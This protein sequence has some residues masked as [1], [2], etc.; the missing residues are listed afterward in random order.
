LNKETEVTNRTR[1]HL[2]DKFPGII[3]WRNSIGYDARAKVYYG[4]GGRGGSD[5]IGMYRGRFIA[6]EAKAPGSHTDPAH[7][8]DQKNFIRVIRESG[9]IA[10]FFESPEGAEA[11]INGK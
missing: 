3:L 7:L 5:L 11:L 6:L 9:G 4:I 1:L 8:A 2:A 10:G